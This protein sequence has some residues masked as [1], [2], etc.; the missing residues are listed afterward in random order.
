MRYLRLVSTAA[1]STAFLLS[2]AGC[3]MKSQEAPA[4]SGP[5]E[6]GTSIAIAIAPD[7]LTQDGASQS[8]I[9]V[10]ARDSNGQPM[11][12]VSLRAE[13]QIA[14]IRADFGSLSARNL[15]TGTDGRATV[16]Y[17]AP[18]APAVAVDN[19]TLVD[20]VIT[21]VGT[22]F[23]N[24][25]PRTA[26]IRLVPP[27]IVVPPDGLKPLFTFTPNAPVDS[28]AVLFDASTS[29]SAPGNPIAGYSWNFGDGGRGTGVTASHSYATAGTYVVA[30]TISDGLGR[31]A[32][33]S[34]SLTVGAGLDPTAAFSSSPAD[35]LVNQPVNFNAAASK[36]APGRTIRSYAWDFGDGTF[37]SGMIASHAYGLP[38]SYVVTLT[39]T[40]DSGKKGTSS[41]TVSVR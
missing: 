1:V 30:L 11:R 6:Y 20:I 7:V 39:V 8:L 32:Q 38:R 13:V 21:P 16:V 36:P 29:S 23:N 41:A 2:L 15:V 31:T 19:G 24:T 28:Q 18:A 40:D 37:G 34:E 26:A 17:T 10:T 25:A 4:L 35:P 9:T 14:G 5:S 27:G 33:K 3:T 12:S 22:D